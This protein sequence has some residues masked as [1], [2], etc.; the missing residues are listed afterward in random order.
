[1]GK[2][3][4]EIIESEAFTSSLSGHHKSLTAN[5]AGIG[6]YVYGPHSESDGSGDTS[7]DWFLTPLRP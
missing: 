5:Y 4:A 1:M 6:D 3:K 2:L 7:W